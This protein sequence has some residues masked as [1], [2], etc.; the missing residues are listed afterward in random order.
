MIHTC[1]LAGPIT[2]LAYGEATDWRVYAVSRLA[3]AGIQG[4]SPMRGKDYLMHET[5]LWDALKDTAEGMQIL[6]TQKGIVTRDRDDC[7]KAD[8][9]LFN[10]LGAARVSI[11]TMVEYGWADANRVPIVTVI[12]PSGNVHEHAFIRELTGFRA[13]TL[14]RGIAI[15]IA[16]LSTREALGA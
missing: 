9:V 2:G 12:E 5:K 7:T 1:Y 3:R 10:L 16:I 6:S 15:A 8:L 14:D 11:G 4:I 13:D